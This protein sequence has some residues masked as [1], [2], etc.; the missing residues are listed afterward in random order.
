MSKDKQPEITNFEY[1]NK[2]LS[3][4]QLAKLTSG[5]Y[6]LVPK[7]PTEAMCRAAGNRLGC[8]TLYKAMI[9]ACDE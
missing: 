5:D 9:G 6:V 3:D 2:R 1:I 8:I 7:K 4:S